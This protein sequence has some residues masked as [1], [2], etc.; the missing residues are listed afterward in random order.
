MPKLEFAPAL[1]AVLV[2]EGGFSNH[3]EDPGGA[4]MKGVTQRV[5]DAW[6]DK[7]G[8]PRQSVRN[9]LPGE[10][11]AIYKRQYWD[12]IKGDDLPAGVAYVVFD[13]AVN[14]GPRRA[15]RSL[16]KALRMN[17]LDGQVGLATVRAANDHPDHDELISAIC[18][19]RMAFVKALRTF[20]TFG[21]GWIRRIQDVK[22][23][24]Q[25]WASGSVG[26]PPMA[27]AKAG[28]KARERDAKKK[29]GTGLADAA[30]GLGA[31]G[32]TVAGTLQQTR[33]HLEPLAGSSEWIGTIVAVLT[34]ISAALVLGGLA[35]RWWTAR[36]A[37]ELAEALA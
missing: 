17:A 14:S 25:A 27:I 33:E 2:H 31:G 36:K 16:Q 23:R 13:Y 7:A 32:G 11:S 20:K 4:T 15:A 12:E 6:R 19:E 37:A 1:E 24:G 29:P 9:I 10:I 26:D 3:P 34:V 18:A 8:L 21:R 22:A 5:Y 28:E 35:Y 30:A